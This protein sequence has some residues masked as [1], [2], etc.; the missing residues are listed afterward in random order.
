MATPRP[1]R[2]SVQGP[3]PGPYRG[4]PQ[5]DFPARPGSGRAARDRAKAPPSQAPRGVGGDPP[6]GEAERPVEPGPRDPSAPG[7]CG[8]GSRNSERGAAG[9]AAAGSEICGVGVRG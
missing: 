5:L 1:A 8:L 2:R 3:S 7:D 4:G 6:V 9:L